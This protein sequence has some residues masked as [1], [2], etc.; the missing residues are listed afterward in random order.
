MTSLRFL[1]VLLGMLPL[2]VLACMSLPG[3]LRK[4]DA[5]ADT[6]LEIKGTEHPATTPAE[7]SKLAQQAQKRVAEMQPIMAELDQF[8]LFGREALGNPPD[9]PE[10]SSF[11]K[12]AQTWSELK[13]C[14]GATIDLGQSFGHT[15]K[16]PK[17]ELRAIAS[18]LDKIPDLKT[19]PGARPI[20]EL[21]QKRQ[22]TIEAAEA[23]AEKVRRIQ[24]AFDTKQYDKCLELIDAA[25]LTALDPATAHR[26]EQLQMHSKFWSHWKNV[27][28][29]TESART[30]KEKLEKLLADYPPPNEPGEE[31]FVETQRGRLKDATA[32]VAIEDLFD[33]PPADF[34]KLLD[35]CE[36]IASQY[37]DAHPRLST[38]LK[39]YLLAQFP[40]KTA[41][42]LPDGIQEVKLKKGTYLQ[43]VFRP[44]PGSSPA[45]Y[46]YFAS[47]QKAKA[48]AAFTTMYLHEF[49]GPPGPAYD[50]QV[51]RIYNDRV[52]DLQ[53]NWQT[54][55]KWG[56]FAT[57]CKKWQQDVD[58]Y[59]SLQSLPKGLNFEDELKHTSQ[60]NEMWSRIKPFLPDE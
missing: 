15:Y 9:L 25:E 59:Y 29:A 16:D 41:K 32:I 3:A 14:Q 2:G 44:V 20:Q 46:Q 43:G 8:D 24:Q 6:G 37:P 23:L 1:V 31:K 35:H 12:T 38:D 22:Q 42:D 53:K 27:P 7:R 26:V 51:A 19:L 54:H 39:K 40:E 47:L 10:A 45:A 28:I 55:P 60:V 57:S 13:K 56:E 21:L 33:S 5:A 30:Q 58:E 50:L 11:E 36:Q 34:G 4:A 49:F 48:G 18:T 17:D 52:R